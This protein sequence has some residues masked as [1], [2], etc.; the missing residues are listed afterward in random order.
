MEDALVALRGDLERLSR[1]TLAAEAASKAAI[2]ARQRYD[3]GLVDFQTVLDT[4]LSLLTTQDT[5]A[6]AGGDV[7]VDHVGLYKGLCGGWLN[8]KLAKPPNEKT[9]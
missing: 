8:N 6:S 5:V 3:S 7:G 9:N 1:L 4:Q 2:M